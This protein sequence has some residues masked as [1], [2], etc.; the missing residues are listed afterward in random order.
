MMKSKKAESKAGSLFLLPNSYL[1][2]F[3]SSFL[4]CMNFRPNLPNP[5]G[6][7]R[8]TRI[9]G[10]FPRCSDTCPRGSDFSPYG[11]DFSPYGSDFSPHSS[12]F[13]LYGADCAI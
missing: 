12:D 11:L 3:N 10:S 2:I 1:L 5:R 8:S 9:A 13:N 7:G 6:F 4:I